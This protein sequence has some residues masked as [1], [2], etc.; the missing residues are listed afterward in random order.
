MRFPGF[1]G[2]WNR[3]LFSDLFAYLS[4]NTLSRAELSN[5]GKVR[6]IHY[7]DVLIKYGEVIDIEHTEIPYVADVSRLRKPDYLSTGDV[8]IADTAEDDTVGKAVEIINNSSIAVVSGLHTIP[9]RPKERFV[10]S[11]LGYYVN[12]AP[13]HTQLHPYMQGIKVTSISKGNIGKTYISSPDLE[14]QQ[15]ITSL[16]NLLS[17]RIEK[18]RQLVEALKSYKRGLLKHIFDDHYGSGWHEVSLGE[19]SQITMGQSPDSASYNIDQIGLPLV[20]G[21]ADIT[22][23]ITTPQRYTSAPTKICDA[24]SIILSVRAPVGS[25]SWANQRL[26]LGR[27]VCAITAQNTKFLYQLL[28]H[29]QDDWKRIEQGGTFTA[30]SG[31][32]ISSFKVS[33]PNKDTQSTISF[34]L[35]KYDAMEQREENVLRVLQ[36]QKAALLQQL[37]I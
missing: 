29:H 11:Y 10:P 15:K 36:R 32:D 2:E 31:D 3:V 25:V 33:V 16:L 5:S 22:D 21:N 12:S 4:N 34:F 27:G 8:V 20:Q 1:E 26:C 28:I 24:G 6:N 35:S 17:S 18:Q 13:F 30:I 19:I 37:F 9:C 14:E 23:G 7:G